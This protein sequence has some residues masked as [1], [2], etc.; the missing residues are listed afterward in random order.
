VLTI[1][2]AVARM[3]VF[4]AGMWG[5]DETPPRAAR[6]AQGD[7]PSAL[8]DGRAAG[9][10]AARQAADARIEGVLDEVRA[11]CRHV[12]DSWRDLWR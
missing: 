10:D 11:A 12:R 2:R 1:V 5:N 7:A 9:E 3:T 4:R 6:Q 8:P